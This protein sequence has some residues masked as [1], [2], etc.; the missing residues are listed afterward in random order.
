MRKRINVLP[1]FDFRSCVSSLWCPADRNYR[2]WKTQKITLF[3]ATQSIVSLHFAIHDSTFKTGTT[4]HRH[5]DD[6]CCTVL[7]F[8]TGGPQPSGQSASCKLRHNNYSAVAPAYSIIKLSGNV[9]WACSFQ[10]KIPNPCLLESE[11]YNWS[12]TASFERQN[13]NFR[14]VFENIHFLNFFEILSN[15]FQKNSKTFRF[16]QNYVLFT[17]RSTISKKRRYRSS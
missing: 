14:T 3:E 16:S 10:K 6:Y 13:L 2:N 9:S 5:A 15:V 1:W 4:A 11:L 8:A 7:Y 12:D 17:R